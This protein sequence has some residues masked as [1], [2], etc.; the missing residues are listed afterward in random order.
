S[1]PATFAEGEAGEVR[2]IWPSPT[3]N[4]A[5]L[6][7]GAYRVTGRVP[8]TSF[9][10]TATVIVKMPVGTVTPPE[11]LVEPFPLSRVVLD[12]DA[13]GRETP[14]MKNRDKFVRGLA[15]TN[16]DSFLYNFR[17]AFGLPQPEGA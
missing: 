5:A 1:V 2:V 11:R 7:P 6:G 8:G 10:P 9:H 14:F 13:Q 16:P 15:A 4:D 17:D 12:R 3:D